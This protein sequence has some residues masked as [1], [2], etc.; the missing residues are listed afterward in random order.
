MGGLERATRTTDVAWRRDGIADVGSRHAT[1]TRDGYRDECGRAPGLGRSRTS[2]CTSPGRPSIARPSLLERARDAADEALQGAEPGALGR[3]L[4][5]DGLKRRPSATRRPRRA[6]GR[7]GV[8]RRVR[9]GSPGHVRSDVTLIEMPARRQRPL[10]NACLLRGID[11]S[12]TVWGYRWAARDRRSSRRTCGGGH[13]SRGEGAA[14]PGSSPPDVP[15]LLLVGDT[16]ADYVTLSASHRRCRRYRCRRAGAMSGT[17]SA[18]DAIAGPLGERVEHLRSRESD[19]VQRRCGPSACCS[20]YSSCYAASR[21]SVGG[22]EWRGCCTLR[23]SSRRR[24]PVGTGRLSPRCHSTSKYCRSCR[25]DGVRLG[26]NAQMVPRGGGRHDRTR[27]RCWLV[28]SSMWSRRTLQINTPLGGTAPVSPEVPGLGNLAFAPSPSPRR[29]RFFWVG[30][31][32]FTTS[33]VATQRRR[34]AVA[35]RSV[36]SG[37]HRDASFGSDVGARSRWSDVHSRSSC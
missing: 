24:V 16:A 34:R 6:D 36:H 17:R 29:A 19:R 37:S 2:S 10:T 1:T 22:H 33:Y 20:S 26:D 4:H 25:R 30:F 12:V 11:E 15:A 31:F 32:F 14:V 7:D 27:H 8:R 5:D 21:R 3:S 28:R 18:F 23:R 13:Q 9:R 35:A